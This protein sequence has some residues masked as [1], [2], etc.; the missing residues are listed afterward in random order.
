MSAS[1]LN[2]VI[3]V[4]TADQGGGAERMSMAVLDGFNALGLDTWLLVGV[5]RTHHPKVIVFNQS[6]FFPKRR[7]RHRRSKILRRIGNTIGLEDFEYPY[8]HRIDRLTGSP[9]D[10]VLCHNLHGDYFDLRA[11]APLSHR[12]P[13]GLRLFDTWMFSG[14]CAYSLGCP[15]WEIGCGQCPDL[16]IPPTIKRDATRFN[17]RRKQ[18]IVQNARLFISAESEWM[19]D[20]ARQSLLAPAA[21]DWR[22]IRGGIDLT[23]FSPGSKDEARQRL[24]LDPSTKILLYVA[25]LGM[26]NPYKDFGTVLR[27]LD[28]IARRS[29]HHRIELLV[30]GSEGPDQLIA[31]GVCVR[32]MG[33]IR[34][35]NHLAD[36]YR[37]ADIYVHAA[38]EEA[39]GN[40][41]VEA[42]ACGT[43]VVTASRGGVLE[44]I[45][46]DRTALAVP[47]RDPGAL[48]G[49][50]CQLLESPP[51]RA[52]LGAAGA[53]AART[54][55]DRQAM[56]RNLI[57]WC[58]DCHSIWHN[59]KTV[60]PSS[61]ARP[62]AGNSEKLQP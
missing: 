45:E 21:I 22:M 49:A 28:E 15:R 30:V 4:N 5:K 55:F 43:P 60:P 44:V 58:R 2:K 31:P 48:A 9:P 53:A 17:W 47:P 18:R 36:F 6:P 11:L 59:T 52:R 23:A 20:R 25:N 12:V 37:A 56:I 35:P 34:E 19:L 61:S 57:D 54:C 29:S 41:V 7:W 14:H 16:T 10:L 24:G 33:Y 62:T 39:F 13:V 32:R 42:L 51:L 27:S 38:I 50:V 1:E 26:E 8:S 40:S 46:Q 3:I